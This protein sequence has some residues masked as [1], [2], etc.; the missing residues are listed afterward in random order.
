MAERRRPDISAAAEANGDGGPGFSLAFMAEFRGS[1]ALIAAEMRRQREDRENINQSIY[2]I[3]IPSLQGTVASG[4]VAIGNAEQ[5][6]PRTGITWDVRRV[7]VVGLGAND[8]ITLYRVSTGSSTAGEQVTNEIT[9]I[10]NQTSNAK[11]GLYSPGL[12]ACLVRAGQS[13]LVAA[14]SGLVATTVTVTWD[15]ISVPDIWLG[16]YLL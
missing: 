1:L 3:T 11:D 10:T 9:Q 16:A 7:T 14:A 15:A 4:A 6:G 13:L 2:P 8:V 5:T 12:G